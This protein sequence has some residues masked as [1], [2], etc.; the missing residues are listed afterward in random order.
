MT[1]LRM[2][3]R[4]LLVHKTRIAFIAI[5][6]LFFVVRLPGVTTPFHQDEF[7]NVVAAETIQSAGSFFAHPPLMQV[8]FVMGHSLTGGDFFR[9]WPLLFSLISF[10]VLYKVVKK[11]AGE[12]A[13]LASILLFTVS[14][15][16]V[17]GSLMAD[18]DGS[19]FATLFI[20]AVYASDRWYDSSGKSRYVWIITISSICALGFLL[21]LSFVLP[22]SAVFTEML[23][24]GPREGFLKRLREGILAGV[25]FLALSG[26]GFFLFKT[27][28]PAFDTALM[29]SHASSYGG[30]SRNWAQIMFQGLKAVFYTSPLLIVPAFFLHK[31]DIRDGLIFII[32]LVFGFIFYFILF[33][34]SQAALDK[35]LMFVIIP[36]SALSGMAIAR[37]FEG[38]VTEEL[39][40]RLWIC[41]LA[42]T[43]SL[44]LVSLTLL[45]Q[46]VVSLYPK[47]LWFGRVIHGAW[48]V[49]TPFNGG[50]GP[51]GFYVSFCFLA[52][53]YI[54]TGIC[55]VG[56]FFKPEIRRLTL[57][58]ILI[59]GLSYNIV[60]I[61]EFT[62]GM[63][64]GSVT[65]V[66]RE[67]VSYIHY[68]QQIDRVTTF[69]DT[70]AYDL[71]SIGKYEGRFYAAPQFEEG[72]K[73][74]FAESSPYFMVVEF[75]LLYDG[76]YKTFFRGC[77]VVFETRSGVI[78]AYVYECTRAQKAL[79]KL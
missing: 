35:Y 12:N 9:I 76:F 1:F 39:R 72:H 16:S 60:F 26:I 52:V 23:F 30:E 64:N 74:K 65:Q 8:W 62:Y 36:L 48:D 29:F 43:T 10:I 14:F 19:V 38:E 20:L 34:F 57:S 41:V 33:D 4:T 79:K 11:R 6:I 25:G 7:K 77:D 50:S 13:A 56:R 31:R 18:V 54:V 59:M 53:S 51:L 2:N 58:A 47:T 21:K 73:K 70:G 17:W 67:A 44:G 63:V 42:G 69:N 45:D 75:P 37:I 3:L 40:R 28:Y 46:N 5:L 68:A 27:F 24:R 49:L 61:Q 15:Y 55:V 32:Y 22:A 78:P 71:V 66:T